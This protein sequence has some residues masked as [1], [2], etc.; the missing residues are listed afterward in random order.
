MHTVFINTSQ[1][2]SSQVYQELIFEKLMEEYNL[3]IPRDYVPL[4]E[5][6]NCANE[7]AY[8]IDSETEIGEDIRLLVYFDCDFPL[9]NSNAANTAKAIALEEMKCIKAEYALVKTLHDIGKVPS[10]VL[11]V[12][13]EKIRRNVMERINT[14][15]EELNI[16]YWN[17]IALPGWE[18]TADYL[19]NHP[20]LQLEEIRHYLS[21]CASKE[22]MINGNDACLEGL[23]N[24]LSRNISANNKKNVPWT[25]IEVAEKLEWAVDAYKNE[26]RGELLQEGFV[27]K[28]QFAYLPLEYRDVKERNR[29]L[30]RLMLCVY[31]C[32]CNPEKTFMENLYAGM[33]EKARRELG[34]DSSEKACCLPQ[35]DC[36]QLA[37]AMQRQLYFCENVCYSPAEAP[38]D[39]SECL[40]Q[41]G[42][43]E[44][45]LIESQHQIPNLMADAQMDYK[46]TVRGLQDAVSAALNEIKEKNDENENRIH[47]YLNRVTS[48]YDRIKDQAL[49]NIPITQKDMYAVSDAVTGADAQ[50]TRRIDNLK[51]VEEQIEQVQNQAELK[52]IQF[53]GRVT[54]TKD[55]QKAIDR[56]RS[57]TDEYFVSLKRTLLKVIAFSLFVVL[58]LAPYAAIQFQVFR[59]V[60]SSLYF[61]FTALAAAAAVYLGWRFFA[62]RWKRKIVRLVRKLCDSFNLSQK[63]NQECLEAYAGF[64]YNQVPR[65]YGLSRYAE[66][67]TE[68]RK[69]MQQR[70]EKMTC[71]DVALSNRVRSIRVWLDGMDV[72]MTEPDE[73][74]STVPLLNPDRGRTENEEYYVLEKEWVFSVLTYGTEGEA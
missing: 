62:G 5:L 1:T 56:V 72:Q 51:N 6:E 32:A 42:S 47:Q 7:L 31:A 33:D 73:Y 71:H 52:V 57:Q 65:C 44:S 11:F 48:E 58:F 17:C 26:R 12:F 45:R 35:V 67:L 15:R 59:S 14:Y 70:R 24:K 2:C 38:S 16:A 68:Y 50:D 3:I 49:K 8:L 9:T 53:R 34:G 21:S 25:G 39:L 10:E 4:N 46:M 74:P 40:S 61:V 60:S 36:V 19:N 54:G 18:E 30:C 66:L 22:A 41:E 27:S 37:H 20:G 69:E 13:G 23:I 63:E 29:S 28:V 43:E 55:V 64:L